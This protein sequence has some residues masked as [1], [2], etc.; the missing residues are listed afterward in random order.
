MHR[1]ERHLDQQVNNSGRWRHQPDTEQ[2]LAIGE[3]VQGG[4]KSRG[5][6]QHTVIK[7][8]P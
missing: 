4:T 3:F 5:S 7:I 1:L 6:R 8:S 2:L